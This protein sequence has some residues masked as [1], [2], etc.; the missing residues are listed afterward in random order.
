M[1]EYKSNSY[2]FLKNADFSQMDEYIKAIEEIK[3]LVVTLK[4]NSKP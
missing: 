4:Q 3:D 1:E 2:E